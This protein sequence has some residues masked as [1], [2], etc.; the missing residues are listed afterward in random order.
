MLAQQNRQPVTVGV[1]VCSVENTA[2]FCKAERMGFTTVM[3]VDG[4]AAKLFALGV[5]FTDDRVQGQAVPC[6]RSYR[7]GKLVSDLCDTNARK[8]DSWW[9]VGVFDAETAKTRETLAL[10]RAAAAARAAAEAKLAADRKAIEDAKAAAEA[11][12]AAD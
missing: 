9:N 6:V 2:T 7:A 12:A 8:A 11:K 4:N 10:E 1:T 5:H 3:T